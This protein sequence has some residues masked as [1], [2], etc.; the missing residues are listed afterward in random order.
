[1]KNNKLKLTHYDLNTRYGFKSV[2]NLFDEGI[3]H[4]KQVLNSNINKLFKALDSKIL[5]SVCAALGI[6]FW[7][8]VC[9]YAGLQY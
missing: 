6:I 5:T 2:I 7:A 9:F 3:Q 1:M 4:K 8:A